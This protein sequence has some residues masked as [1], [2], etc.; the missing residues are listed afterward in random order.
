MPLAKS[1][2]A[3]GT[4]LSFVEGAAREIVSGWVGIYGSTPDELRLFCVL[5]PGDTFVDDPKYVAQALTQVCLQPTE[6]PQAIEPWRRQALRLSQYSATERVADFLAD[7]YR[8]LLDADCVEGNTYRFP[9]TQSQ[10]GELLGLSC[11]HIN[12]TLKLLRPRF[13]IEGHRVHIVQHQHGSK[14]PDHEPPAVMH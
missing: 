10:M 9:L 2:Y 12:R 8:R 1:L 5:L 4:R 6:K 14:T 7:A 3:A 13:R 11:V